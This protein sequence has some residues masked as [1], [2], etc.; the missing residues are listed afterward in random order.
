MLPGR[1]A[2]G[3]RAE[4]MTVPATSASR[5]MGGLEGS[6]ADEGGGAGDGAREAED[7]QRDDAVEEAAEGGKF[8]L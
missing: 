5:R 2:A 1:R 3:G 7:D 4:T 8:S 6:G